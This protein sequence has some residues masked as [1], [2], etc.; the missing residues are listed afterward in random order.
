MPI[1]GNAHDD[2]D[3]FGLAH[4]IL[5]SETEPLAVKIRA[6]KMIDKA[7]GETSKEPTEQD[8]IDYL[9]QTAE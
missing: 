4:E 2:R 3:L 5:T 6:L 1:V 8:V 7:M 9:R